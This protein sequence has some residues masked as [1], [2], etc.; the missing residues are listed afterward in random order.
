MPFV[1]TSVPRALPLRGGQSPRSWNG[2][3]GSRHKGTEITGLQGPCYRPRARGN[4]KRAILCYWA[5]SDAASARAK[6]RP[7]VTEMYFA[8][9]V[10]VPN[11][12]ALGGM[13]SVSR[14][15]AINTMSNSSLPSKKDLCRLC[16][17][18]DVECRLRREI[19][20]SDTM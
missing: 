9:K 1:P 20:A 16:E 2:T 13:V 14:L 7:T 4:W 17:L 11:A 6:R 18:L 5:A 10:P 3:S 8:L 19:N 12:R 15:K